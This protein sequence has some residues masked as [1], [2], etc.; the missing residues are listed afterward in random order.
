MLGI[1]PSY[2][3]FLTK[4]ANNFVVAKLL[5]VRACATC[6]CSDTLRCAISTEA[7]QRVSYRW[8]NT[9]FPFSDSG[10]AALWIPLRTIHD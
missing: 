6:R 8:L 7:L 5:Q 1:L 2:C 10:K 3:I 4:N 9:I